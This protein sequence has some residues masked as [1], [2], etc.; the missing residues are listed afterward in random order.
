MR[1]HAEVRQVRSA[2]KRL[3]RTLGDWRDLRRFAGLSP[4]ADKRD[5]CR[6]P[7]YRRQQDK[8]RSAAARAWRDLKQAG[9]C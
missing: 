8:L 1:S 7:G 6:P 3:Q 9:A 5:K 4:S 2:A